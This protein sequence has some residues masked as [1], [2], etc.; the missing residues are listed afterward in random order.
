[1]GIKQ[2]VPEKYKE[3]SEERYLAGMYVAQPKPR[4]NL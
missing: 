4:D 3:K 2:S 1:M